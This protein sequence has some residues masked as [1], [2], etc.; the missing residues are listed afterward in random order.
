MPSYPSFSLDTLR[1]LP[2]PKFTDLGPAECD[3][4]SNWF[5]WLQNETL[6]PFPHMHEDPVRQQIDDAVCKALDLDGEWIATVRREL[7]REPSVTDRRH[8][9]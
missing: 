3:M 8:G 4:L 9:A 2:V 5:D 1:S 6:Q 7:S